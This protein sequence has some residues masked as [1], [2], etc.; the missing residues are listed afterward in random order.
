VGAITR[1][2]NLAVNDLG[3]WLVEADTDNADTDAD[4]VVIRDG[5]LYLR[6]GDALADPAGATINTFD[7]INL[8]NQG[9]SGW[10]FFLSGTAGSG[11]DSGIYYDTSLVLQESTV[12]TAPQFSPGTPYIGFFEA[13]TAPNDGTRIFVVATV[14]DPA[15]ASTVDQALVVLTHDGSGNLLSESVIAKEGDV[16]AGQ[17]ESIATFGTGPHESAFNDAGQALYF[18]DLTGDTST[19]GAIYLDGT[20]LAQEGSASPIAGRNYELLSSRGRDLS[21]SGAW[22]IKANLDGDTA[23]DEIIVRNGSVIVQ[24]GMTLPAFAP[25]KLTSTGTGSG[26]VQIDD[27]GNVLWFGDWDDPD[28]DVDTGLFWNDQLIVQEGV[29]MI[30]G[31]IVDTIASGQDAFQISDN[32]QWAIFEAVLV[33]GKEGAFLIELQGPVSIELSQFEASIGQRTVELS[34]VTSSEYQHDGFWVYRAASQ[35]GDYVRLNRDLI[36]GGG[37]EYRFVDSDVQG[38]TEYWY[39]LGA[40]SLSGQEDLYGPTAIITPPWIVVNGLAPGRPNPFTRGTTL[41][42]D[43][44]SRGPVRLQIFDVAG[45]LVR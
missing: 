37:P 11:D 26:P 39:K 10:N 4:Q 21:N 9:H 24:E 36:R 5:S 16:P 18:T 13:R 33:G 23:D 14:D 32:G 7:S 43:L 28:T 27:A 25:F 15:I 45:R 3:E 12:S 2:D 31:E 40:V 6:E 38:G 29:T 8:N 34:W 1:I 44:P 41:A 17:T 42:L 22:V 35:H 20:L 30:G 19:D